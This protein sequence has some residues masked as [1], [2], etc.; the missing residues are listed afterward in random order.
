MSDE[1]LQAMWDAFQRHELTGHTDSP[2]VAVLAVL[3]ANGYR[4]CAEGQKV[5]QWCD[6]A[7]K[8]EAEVERLRAEKDA[9]KVAAWDKSSALLAE[10]NALRADAERY[11][12]IRD[13]AKEELLYPARSGGE[14]PDLRTKWSIPTLMCSNC[15]G[16]V[17]SFDESIDAARGES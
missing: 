8:A 10:R 3:H 15:I 11:R 12:W 5:T 6:R 2:M 14:V 4:R 7:N 9:I 16:G 17:R 13:N 1:L